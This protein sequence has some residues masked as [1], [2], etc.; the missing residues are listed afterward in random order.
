MTFGGT[1]ACSFRH[2]HITTD[3]TNYGVANARWRTERGRATDICHRSRGQCQ[4]LAQ[5]NTAIV[6][7]HKCVVY[8][9][10][11]TVR[12]QGVAVAVVVDS[13]L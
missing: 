5:P 1:I 4:L 3:Q 12:E 9:V 8:P 6:A 10:L 13:L 11:Q 7:V 2:I